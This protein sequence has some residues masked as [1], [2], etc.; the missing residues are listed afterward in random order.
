MVSDGQ[1]T[2]AETIDGQRRIDRLLRVGCALLW[3][4]PQNSTPLAG[5][6]QVVL[7]DPARSGQLIARAATAALASHR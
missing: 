1:F 6:Q 3:L 2:T 7:D 4:A 5:G